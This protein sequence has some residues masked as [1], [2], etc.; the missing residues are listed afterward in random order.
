MLVGVQFLIEAHGPDN[1]LDRALRRALLS[2]APRARQRDSL[3]RWTR[4]VESTILA[5]S[6]TQ[7][8]TS[9]AILISGYLQLSCGLSLYHWQT[10]V[11]LAWFS[12]ITHLTT[13]TSQ[14]RYFRS[15]PFMAICRILIMGMVLILLSVAFVPTGYAPQID[16]DAWQEWTGSSITSYAY[17]MSSPAVCLFSPAS[18]DAAVSQIDLFAA[19]SVSSGYTDRG[20]SYNAPLVALS[21]T[22]LLTSFGSRVIR[23]ST[24]LALTFERW[25]KV[26]PSNFLQRRYQSARN[27]QQMRRNRVLLCCYR[28][29]L[30]V[31][32]TFV[33]AFYETGNS[34]VWEIL[35]LSAALAWGTVR[36]MGLRAQSQI[37]DEDQWGFG[38]VLPLLLSVLPIWWLFTLSCDRRH[39]TTAIS[40]KAWHTKHFPTLRSIKKATWFRSLTGLII[41]MLTI[42]AVYLVFDLPGASSSGLS[43]GIDEL[44]TGGGFGTTLAKYVFASVFCIIVCTFF[45]CAC[46][47]FHFRTAKVSQPEN[48]C[49]GAVSVRG[50][51]RLHNGLWCATVLTILALQVAFIILGLIHPAWLLNGL[52]YA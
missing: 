18:K 50:R 35:W 3:E 5:F 41:G 12:A 48:T 36:L 51:R 14:K 38:Q 7:L 47:A 25:L 37:A 22:Y 33:E 32:I 28:A 1:P 43:Y 45:V 44:T 40:C 46:L 10:V 4:A 26:R 49:P 31:A 16:G 2:K 52:I 20:H 13:L 6:D 11:N 9:L 15:Y 30:L 34:M 39:P 24:P 27:R 42:L 17:F 29:L 8:V 19:S 21:L 23:I